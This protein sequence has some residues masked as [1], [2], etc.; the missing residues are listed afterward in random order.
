MIMVSLSGLNKPNLLY[1]SLTQSARAFKGIHFFIFNLKT[2][3][4][5]NCLSSNVS[6]TLS[7]ILKTNIDSS[8]PSASSFFNCP[9]NSIC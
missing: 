2:S 4:L 3:R 8:L 7:K 1:I 6:L 9:V 5:C